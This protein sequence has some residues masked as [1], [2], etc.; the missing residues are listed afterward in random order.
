MLWTYCQDKNENA[1]MQIMQKSPGISFRDQEQNEISLL[2][3]IMRSDKCEVIRVIIHR[4]DQ[5]ESAKTQCLVLGIYSQ[6]K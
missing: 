5:N 6:I 1:K 3:S 2:L 4:Q